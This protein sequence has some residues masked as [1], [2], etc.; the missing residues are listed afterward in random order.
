MALSVTNLSCRRA[1][2]MV[3]R[4]VGLMLEPGQAATV[5]GPN[6]SGK[7]TLLR[8]VAGL[9]TPLEGDMVLMGASITADRDRYLEN[10]AYSGHQDALKP[11]LTVRE[12][13]SVWA[14]VLE[15]PVGRVDRAM[16]DFDL[17]ALGDYPVQHCSAGQKRRLGLARLTLAD[18]ALWVLDEPT[19]SLDTANAEMFS[20]C[21]RDHCRTGGMALVATHLPMNTGDG[22]VIDMG[23]AVAAADDGEAEADP[24][25]TAGWT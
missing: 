22:P 19:V 15:A 10:V 2:R 12:N 6:G 11:A 24:F 4:R 3:F 20:A 14:G 9:L 5:V 7:S 8:A 23:Q 25:L 17:D 1:G 16:A 21:I 18:H 13:L